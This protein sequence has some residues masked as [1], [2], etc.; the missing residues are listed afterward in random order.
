MR[1]PI[2][3]DTES[4]PLSLCPTYTHSILHDTLHLQF[5]KQRPFGLFIVYFTSNNMTDKTQTIKL[6]KER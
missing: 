6:T 2:N 1:C 5:V 4:T 3:P